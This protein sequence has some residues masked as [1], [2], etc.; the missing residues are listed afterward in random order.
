MVKTKCIVCSKDIPQDKKTCPSCASSLLSGFVKGLVLLYPLEEHGIEKWHLNKIWEYPEIVRVIDKI[1]LMDGKE[2]RDNELSITIK[3]FELIDLIEDK[4]IKN[5][6]NRL[7][8]LIMDSKVQSY[9]EQKDFLTENDGES[10]KSELI[11]FSDMLW[12]ILDDFEFT[13]E[14]IDSI[15][16]I[17][18]PY[19]I[20]HREVRS[21]KSPEL[22]VFLGYQFKLYQNIAR[23]SNF[24]EILKIRQYFLRVKKISILNPPSY[25]KTL[26]KPIPFYNR[27]EE[28]KLIEKRE[29][30]GQ[31]F[32]DYI[33]KI[34]KFTIN[35]F[36]NEADSNATQIKE[37]SKLLN[38]LKKLRERMYTVYDHLKDSLKDTE[39]ENLFDILNKR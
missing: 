30:Q 10:L 13:N 34:N 36:N 14:D 2:L 26:N 11:I 37:F 25:K 8:Q 7:I 28:R 3:V 39:R 18:K 17:D 20:L 16:S 24:L 1:T 5:S 4:E 6:A 21:I 12:K 27:I 19:D 38:N 33:T 22:K 31:N 29:K 15:L 9:E 35:E 32:K 23:C